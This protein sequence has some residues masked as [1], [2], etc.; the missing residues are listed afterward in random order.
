MKPPSFPTPWKFPFHPEAGNQTSILISES[1]DGRE[2]IATR[3]NSGA[4][5]NAGA[6]A[7]LPG[8]A[9]GTNCPA[10][11]LCAEVTAAFGRETFFRSP[12]VT[13]AVATCEWSAIKLSKA[14][15]CIRSMVPPHSREIENRSGIKTRRHYHNNLGGFYFLD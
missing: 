12:Q 1:L 7:P 5:L 8:S 10:G 3:Q 15:R 4:S 9:A 6:A 13:A 11:T 14:T 2:V